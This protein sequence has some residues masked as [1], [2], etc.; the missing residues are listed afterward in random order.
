MKKYKI[1][2]KLKQKNFDKEYISFYYNYGQYP[3]D[4][5]QDLY[6]HLCENFLNKKIMVL[7]NCV[8]LNNYN[9]EEIIKIL[10]EEIDSL[11]GY[12]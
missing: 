6:K 4:E 5:L 10:Q 3:I 9:K 7:P 11:N 2:Y 1:N 8:E 12:E